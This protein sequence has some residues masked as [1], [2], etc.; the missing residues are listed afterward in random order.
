MGVTIAGGGSFPGNFILAEATGCCRDGLVINLFDSAPGWQ[1]MLDNGAGKDGVVVLSSVSVYGLESGDNLSADIAAVP[2]DALAGRFLEQET[3]ILAACRLMDVPVV[4]LRCVDMIGTGMTGR[5]RDVANGIYR[6]TY[7][8]IK[9]NMAETSVVHAR[10]VA[11]MAVKAVGMSGVFVVTD[12]K[13]HL[14]RD[15]AEALSA[16][17]DHKRIPVFSARQAKVEAFVADL[18][19]LGKAGRKRWLRGQYLSLT[20]DGVPLLD[21]LGYVPLDTLDFLKKHQYSDEDI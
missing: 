13:R 9:G 4:I 20:F 15:V 21:A 7:H 1:E 16:R 2:R 12:G 10:D 3:A 17:I 5:W 18:M 6:A 14:V 19:T 8:H 11:A